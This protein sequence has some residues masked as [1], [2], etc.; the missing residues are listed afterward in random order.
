MC[1]NRGCVKNLQVQ[2]EFRYTGVVSE[3]PDPIVN[4]VE[5]YK[6]HSRSLQL[7]TTWN[8]I[9]ISFVWNIP[10]VTEAIYI[11]NLDKNRSCEED[12][13]PVFQ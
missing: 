3:K 12:G 11:G 13:I 1:R 10:Q 6:N 4:L 7:K 2:N 9:T 5:S 8:E